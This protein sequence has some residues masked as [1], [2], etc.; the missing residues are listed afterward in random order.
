MIEKTNHED[1]LE[2]WKTTY[3]GAMHFNDLLMRLRTLGLP[4][5]ITITGG[6]TAYTLNVR[7]WEVSTLLIGII[8]ISLSVGLSMLVRWLFSRPYLG[9]ALG[10]EE[11]V[12][13][14]CLKATEKT[15]WKIVLVLT[16]V[17][18][19]IFWVREWSHTCALKNVPLGA[20]LIAFGLILL[21]S[22]YILDRFYY[23]C[24]LIGAVTRLERVENILGFEVTRTVSKMTPRYRSA[25][26]ITTLY[27]L[28]G[29]IGYTM[30]LTILVFT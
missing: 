4:A 27:F 30:F 10:K 11:A 29:I 7:P 28:P 23:Y 3:K 15:M 12:K 16:Y 24:L 20:F 18:T 14:I 2:E 6:A 13:D 1:L 9:T 19:I 25:V 17:Y 21:V 5:I 22:F 8:L 26:V